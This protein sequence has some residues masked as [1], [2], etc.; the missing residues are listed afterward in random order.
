M[1]CYG[2]WHHTADLLAEGTSLVKH[3]LTLLCQVT[4]CSL[5]YTKQ[6]NLFRQF[7]DEKHKKGAFL[8]HG[9]PSYGQV[10][11][12]NRLI[13]QLRDYSTLDPFKFSFQSKAGEPSIKRLWKFLAKWVGLNISFSIDA[14]TQQ[15]IIRR[16]Y[17][18]WQTQT[19]ILI[20][21]NSH[22]IEEQYIDKFLQEFWQAFVNITNDRVDQPSKHY[23]LMFLIAHDDRVDKWKVPLAWQV[24]PAW[25]P[26]LPLKLEKLAEFS[27]KVLEDWILREERLPP[28]LKA[29]DI[30]D[31]SEGIPEDALNYICECCGYDEWLDLVK[32]RLTS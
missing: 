23:F 12:L 17:K 18:R 22:V 7:R 5:N 26:R 30:L 21:N 10:W 24:D 29:K 2:Y 16:L 9:A 32:Y 14:A 27:E 20:L 11:L 28:H 25:E 15:E 6:G 4:K 1:I 13:R 19:V 31:N 8:I 3:Q